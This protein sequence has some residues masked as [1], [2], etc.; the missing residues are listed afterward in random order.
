MNAENIA[1]MLVKIEEL[2]AKPSLSDDVDSYIDVVSCGNGDDIFSSGKE[3]GEINLAKELL[4]IFKGQ[5]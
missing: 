3:E 1:K 2:A 5:S 4:Q